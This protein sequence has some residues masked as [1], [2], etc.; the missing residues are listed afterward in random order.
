MCH[1]QICIK[2]IILIQHK[3][4]MGSNDHEYG[5]LAGRVCYK[6]FNEPG[7]ENFIKRYGEG[8]GCD[9]CQSKSK[10]HEMS[11]VMKHILTRI[12]L[13]YDEPVNCMGYDGREGGYL[14]AET[15]DSYD[16]LE[17]VGLDT[18]NQNLFEEIANNLPV[19]FWCDESPYQERYSDEFFSNW[20][21]FTDLVKFR[22]RYMFLKHETTNQE[23]SSDPVLLARV[24]DTL[25]KIFQ[26]CDLIKVISR[27]TK[28]YRARYFN[29]HD[30]FELTP[31]NLCTP[32]KD[33]CK[34]S[35][36]SPCGIALFY[37]SEDQ[38]TAMAEVG[39]KVKAALA[40]FTLKKDIPLIDLVNVPDI[41][42]L[43]GESFELRDRIKFLRNFREEF[44]QPIKKDGREHVEY[45]PTQ[46]IAEYCK[47]NLKYRG[48][49]IKG[50]RFPSSVYPKG[51][52]YGLYISRD[53]CGV[54]ED[55]LSK[56]PEI[57]LECEEEIKIIC[58]T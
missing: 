18:N 46:I 54:R 32:P 23:R 26:E 2:I 38:K 11:E 12:F 21:S 37:S 25:A 47:Y 44:C 8:I 28:F 6:C 31:E 55:D 14:G 51:I 16:I 1:H 41:P 35:R 52:S 39:I 13:E 50:F 48:C 43:F 7:L 36:M 27:G 29:S 42:S 53:E 33:K 9:Y 40:T 17:Q 5:R 45:V 57:I 4:I 20:S 3:S 19:D 34:S 30:P 15:Y 22:C 56:T 24:L 58:K 49:P 10:S